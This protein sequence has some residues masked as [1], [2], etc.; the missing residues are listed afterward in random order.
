MRSFTYIAVIIVSAVVA[1]T[2]VG[3]GAYLVVNTTSER[4]DQASLRMPTRPIEEEDTPDATSEAVSL[5]LSS[6]ESGVLEHD[7]GARMEIS[8]GALTEAVT[9][10]ISEVEPPP[11]PARVGKVY[12]F[13]VGD[14][15]ILAPITLH[16]P[17]ELEPGVD[18]SRIVPMHWD[19]DLEVWVV[20]EGEVDE[21]TQMVDVTVLDLSR[22][23]TAGG[24]AQS[25]PSAS[26]VCIRP[27]Y[28]YIQE[29]P[30][31]L[32]SSS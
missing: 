29:L 11:S 1:I 16:I 27:W 22:F 12:Y 8:Q 28:W 4:S 13:S 7:S 20:L 23:T 25:G 14:T 24:E 6:G 15:P 2:T 26:V 18:S 31:Q 3:V 21:S 9:V 19:D 30:L 17:Y 5:R 32:R 10:S